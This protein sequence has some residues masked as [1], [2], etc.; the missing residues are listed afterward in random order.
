M[1]KVA[2]SFSDHRLSVLNDARV[3]HRKGNISLPITLFRATDLLFD[4]RIQFRE[5]RALTRA[6]NSYQLNGVDRPSN[7]DKNVGKIPHIIVRHTCRDDPTSVLFSSCGFR[8]MIG[9]P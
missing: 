8:E 4:K 3:N 7:S 9:N 1:R 2:I 6:E 5:H